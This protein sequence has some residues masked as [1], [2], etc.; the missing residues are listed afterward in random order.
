MHNLELDMN[1]YKVKIE[2]NP[3][4]RNCHECPFYQ[5]FGEDEDFGY[6]IYACALTNPDITG[7]ALHR[8]AECP[9]IGEESTKEPPTEKQEELARTIAS[10]MDMYKGFYASLR[11]PYTKEAYWKFIHDNKK[12]LG[13]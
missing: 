10:K 8:P 1:G 11:I 5:Y 4:P 3:L 2:C 7:C 6:Y 13:K 9:L 12:E